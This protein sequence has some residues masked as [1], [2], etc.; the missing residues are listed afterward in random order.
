M[1]FSK[2]FKDVCSGGVDAAID[3]VHGG[4]PKVAIFG[5]LSGAIY[6]ISKIEQEEFSKK[7]THHINE[8]VQKL[9]SFINESSTIEEPSEV[10]SIIAKLATTLK[11]GLTQ[12]NSNAK[13]TSEMLQRFKDDSIK[14][15]EEE[16]T[17]LLPTMRSSFTRK[18]LKP[19]LDFLAENKFDLFASFFSP[20]TKAPKAPAPAQAPNASAASEASAA[21]AASATSAASSEN[22]APSTE[23]VV[24]VAEALA[25]KEGTNLVLGM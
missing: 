13:V 8:M 25:V 21:P 9:E 6:G 17:K 3:E 2:L 24:N 23:A 7:F 18:L 10:R 22:T 15:I 12:L 20:T 14:T 1:N 4:I 16:R 11:D 19:I 5:A